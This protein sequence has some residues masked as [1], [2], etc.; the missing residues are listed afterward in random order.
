MVPNPAS[1]A[2]GAIL[3]SSASRTSSLLA[4]QRA[5]MGFNIERD[6]IVFETSF[7][8]DIK[9]L[10]VSEIFVSLPVSLLRN[11]VFDCNARLLM[12]VLFI[13]EPRDPPRQ[14]QSALDEIFEEVLERSEPMIL[15][16]SRIS[17]PKV[18][19]VTIFV[20]VRPVP[21]CGAEPGG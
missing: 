20:N 13:R 10:S 4:L 1:R 12:C 15:S 8:T 14:E 5:E 2:P 21:S 17:P 16:L 3:S 6:E 18:A 19:R 9:L 11:A 7:A